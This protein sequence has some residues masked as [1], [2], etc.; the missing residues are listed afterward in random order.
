MSV[1][2]A[3]L[4]GAIRYEIASQ[5]V[6]ADICHCSMRRKAQGSAFATYASVDRNEFRW[7]SGEELVSYCECS[8]NACRISCGV[9]GST[10]G[11]AEDV[12]NNSVTL[13]TV[14]GDSPGG[15]N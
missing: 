13:G 2:G 9:C 14:D 12:E 1:N 10:L 7:A 8:P 11:G 3:C 15:R 4:C 6:D 5:L